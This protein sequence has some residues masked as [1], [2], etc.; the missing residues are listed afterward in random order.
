MPFENLLKKVKEHARAKMLDTDAAKGKAGV[1]LG[2]AEQEQAADPIRGQ[3]GALGVLGMRARRSIRAHGSR[4]LMPYPRAKEVRA[5]ARAKAKEQV[6]GREGHHRAVDQSSMASAISQRIKQPAK[7]CQIM[8][9]SIILLQHQQR[10]WFVPKGS[11]R[12]SQ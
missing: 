9:R 8:I 12:N 1:A 2:T 11:Y 5:K 10:K 6:K 4:M 7:Q 3:C